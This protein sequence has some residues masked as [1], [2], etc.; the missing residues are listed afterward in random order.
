M[1]PSQEQ[2]LLAISKIERFSPAPRILAKAMTFLRDPNSGI[3]DIAELIKSDTALTAQII[4]GANSAFYGASLRVS[5]L[6]QAVLKIGFRESI[7][8]L[9]L[10]ASQIIAAAGLDNYGIAA[11][12]FWA[13]SLL[14]GLLLEELA[15][16]TGAIEPAEARAAGLLRFIGRLA[17]NQSLRELGCGVFWDGAGSMEAWELEN[18]GFSHTH[19]GAI[20]LRAW[21]FSEQMVQAIEF[22]DHPEKAPIPNWIAEALQFATTILPAGLDV[23]FAKS[24]APA[25]PL[26]ACE[27]AE[28]HQLTQE[29]VNSM[30]AVCRAGFNSVSR[31]LWS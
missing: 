22:Q 20:L 5:S 17:I 2:F 6:D 1:K 10:A 4:R 29:S 21:H 27:F 23:S 16:T 24:D 28:R 31:N 26:A 11:E 14:H 13:E 7:R 18:V 15:Q 19:A 8:L 9:N 12:D 30:L 25:P 3:D